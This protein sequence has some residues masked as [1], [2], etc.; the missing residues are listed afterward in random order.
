MNTS[1]NTPA[2]PE[3]WLQHRHSHIASYAT[4]TL[5]GQ[6]LCTL[7]HWQINHFHRNMQLLWI[8]MFYGTLCGQIKGE[9]CT[10]STIKVWPWRCQHTRDFIMEAAWVNNAM[11]LASFMSKRL[12]KPITNLDI[13]NTN[14]Y[15]RTQSICKH[16][17]K[18]PWCISDV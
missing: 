16:I 3:Y 9:Q 2:F 10:L 7:G 1:G 17:A 13:N 12:H 4:L 14:T 6:V 15:E 8:N 18:H 5:S 11:Q